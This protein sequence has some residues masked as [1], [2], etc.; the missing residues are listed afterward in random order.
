MSSNVCVAGLTAMPSIMDVNS[1]VAVEAA[2]ADRKLRRALLSSYRRTYVE[3]LLDD[4]DSEAFV[5]ATTKHAWNYTE[6]QT[7]ST[8]FPTMLLRTDWGPTTWRNFQIWA[9]V[10]VCGRLPLHFFGNDE[11]PTHLE[12][13]PRCDG[14]NV[15]I[16]HVLFLWKCAA[17]AYLQW[18][19][20]VGLSHLP[21][22]SVSWPAV[23][24]YLFAERLSFTQDCVALAQQ[25]V[26]YVAMQVTEVA[27]ALWPARVPI[28]GD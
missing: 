7:S 24:T 10:R 15:D 16:C 28:R 26:E 19:Q 27:R 1:E 23:R 13:C 20:D 5:R 4:Y 18:A 14:S 25:R 12:I 11:M 6:F 21:L 3:P 2:R 8:A 22:A 17:P 9:C